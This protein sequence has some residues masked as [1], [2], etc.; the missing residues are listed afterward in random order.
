M[1]KKLNN[2]KK[3]FACVGIGVLF[4]CHNA[5]ASISLNDQLSALHSYQA[6]FTQATVAN[7]IITAKAS[8]KVWIHR[9]WQMRW[10]VKKPNAQTLLVNGKTIVQ[11]SPD[12]NQATV[13]NMNPTELSNAGLLLASH[14]DLSNTFV[15]RNRQENKGVSSYILTPKKPL[16]LTKIIL[17]FSKAGL[18]SMET[19]NTLGQKNIFEFSKVDTHSRIHANLF[20][21]KPAKGMDVLKAGV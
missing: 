4:I 3:M 20:K 21:F 5:M 11:I 6:V 10:Q 9:P 19:W 14:A 2:V 13:R 18:V 16:Q 1:L 15:I 7:G 8:G 12:L 17:N